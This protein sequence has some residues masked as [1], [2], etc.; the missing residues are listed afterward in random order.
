MKKLLLLFAAMLL[1]LVA[2]ADK[3]G[4]CGTNVY[5][6]Y[7]ESTQRLTIYGE[8]PMYS[9][10]DI[11][12]YSYPWRECSIKFLEIGD[13]VTSVGNFNFPYKGMISLSFP[14]S[15]TSI[16]EWAF[17]GCGSLTSITL[18]KSVTK[19]GKNAFLCCDNLATIISEIENP[20]SIDN[21][22]FT[23]VLSKAKLIV[24][25]GTISKYKATDGWKG[26]ANIVEAT[27]NEE[28]DITDNVLVHSKAGATSHIC[29]FHTP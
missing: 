23:S 17:L 21:S 10:E 6:S 16:G 3:S 24:P 12:D 13:G 7:N 5:Y 1:P 14:N 25:K 28:G 20:F 2:S 29:R 19:I 4:K 22:V 9:Y 8:G 18:P 26:F 15:M 27:E 11:D